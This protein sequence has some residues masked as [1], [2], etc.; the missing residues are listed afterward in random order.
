MFAQNK[1][2]IHNSHY[3]NYLNYFETNT[4]NETLKNMAL[5]EIRTARLP[6]C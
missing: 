4:Q 5:L 1:M 2:M 6:R 3:L